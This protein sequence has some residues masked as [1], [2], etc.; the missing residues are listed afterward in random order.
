MTGPASPGAG[1]VDLDDP[2][3]VQEADVR[4]TLPEVAAAAA[5]VRAAAALAAE[6]L[7]AGWA[8]EGRPRTVA[9]LATGADALAG[10]V[11][12]T[13][14][15]GGCPVV[16]LA[17]P[18]PA[19]VGAMDVVLAVCTDGERPEVLEA[20][21]AAARRGP[22]LLAVGPGD[23]GLSR[24]AAQAGAP[25]VALPAPR[26]LWSLAVP[27]LAAAD[28][29]QLL[30][31]PLEVEAAAMRLEQV[32]AACHPS[33]DTL[34]N[35]GSGLALALAGGLPQLL[36]T[37]R[38]AALAAEAGALACARRAGLPALH[39]V[40]GPEQAALWRGPW[41]AERDIFADPDSGGPQPP[42]LAPVLLRDP[43]AEEPGAAQAAQDAAAAR[44]LLLRE[45]AAEGVGRLERLASLI[46]V[47]DYA[48]AYL[49]LATRPGPA[50]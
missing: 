41:A 20:F 32:A 1:G 27:L 3:A 37:S 26:D 5:R 43:D 44:G 16:G 31:E 23:C 49:A 18:L 29:L 47:L 38:L 15:G 33:R 46:G 9:V 40:P 10:R 6:V 45:V 30:A 25:Y 7:P 34:V 36:G 39:G 42:R 19:W 8:E 11:L 14:A 12:A 17:G 13:L 2:R 48:A 22:R 50:A 24:R 35:P 28:L 21:A 4:G